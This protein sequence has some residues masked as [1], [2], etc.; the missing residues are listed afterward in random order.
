MYFKNQDLPALPV[1]RII[2]FSSARCIGA[3]EQPGKAFLI[4]DKY[5]YNGCED[6]QETHYLLYFAGE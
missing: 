3:I 1:S 5:R 6:G 4:D 2:G